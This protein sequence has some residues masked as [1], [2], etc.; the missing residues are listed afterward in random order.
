[1]PTTSS[2]PSAR[3]LLGGRWAISLRGWLIFSALLLVVVPAGLKSQLDL[4]AQS[5]IVIALAS[6]LTITVLYLG[7]GL[8]VFRRRHTAPVP[9]AW[10]IALGAVSGAARVAVALAVPESRA[11]L[12]G[13]WSA[14]VSATLYFVPS[15]VLMAVLITYLVAVTDWYAAERVRLMR[16]E[17]DAEAAR[18]RAVG[19]LNAARAVI[20]TR[21]QNALEQQLNDLERAATIDAS[22]AGLSDALLDTAAGYI[23]PE[24]HRLWQERDPG[25]RRGTLLDIERASL[26]APLPIALPYA[27]WAAVVVPSAAAHYGA[28]SWLGTALAVLAAMAVLYPLG[29]AAVRRY[30]PAPHYLRARL[31]AL[32]FMV[33]AVAA[34][35][36]LS[37]VVR[38]PSTSPAQ[39]L[40]PLAFVVVA[41]IAVSWAQAALRTQD[42][43]LRSLRTHA[44]EAEFERLALEAATEQMHRE[45]AL[46]LHGTVQAGLV[47]S[48]YSIQDAVNRGD[49]VALEAAIADAR[50]A[51][52]QV[53]SHDHPAPTI[54]LVELAQQ[55]DAKWRGLIAITWKL[56]SEPTTD[57]VLQRID[58]VIQECL[59]NA[60]IHGA[61]T[62]ATV[63]IVA[64]DE[65]LIV[66][67]TD[68]GSGLGDGK[69]GL[70]S[71][72]LNEATAGQWS[73]ASVPNGGAQVRAVVPV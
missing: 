66:E 50:F 51:I 29:R 31:I 17:V 18:L 8:T 7:A 23:R 21:I 67:I 43:R 47:A 25:L 11:A 55:F 49:T 6:W 35:P 59:A 63:H 9:V 30:A 53:G 36:A 65:Q 57:V 58:T 72:V 62:E 28:F 3:E 12:G 24:S 52:A 16:F 39:Q 19:A 37:L 60:S 71:A 48:A 32:V 33:G 46:Y 68:N 38:P 22:D 20:T 69:P 42:A 14:G 15:S 10:L 1:M 26:A 2:R 27:L 56:P 5:I 41:T 45:L 44:E 64:D 13:G 34:V 73:I 61:A 70:G 40:L 4:S 54:D